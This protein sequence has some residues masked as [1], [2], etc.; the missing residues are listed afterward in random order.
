MSE[1]GL[2]YKPFHSLQNYV[3]Y[4]KLYGIRSN[5][6]GNILLFVPIGLLLPILSQWYKKWHKM[7]IV[8]FCL[9]LVIEGIQGI[10][11]RG[12]FDI[13]DLILNTIGTMVGW[14]LWK[15]ITSFWRHI[16]IKTDLNAADNTKKMGLTNVVNN[17]DIKEN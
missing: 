14:M 11:R 1:P 9:S 6:I 4:I 2:Q 12:Y 13:D 5:L 3:Y 15:T 17:Q 16:F 8:G 10:T 7:L